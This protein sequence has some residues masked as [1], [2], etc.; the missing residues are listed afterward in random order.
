[1][2]Q[3]KIPRY[4][5]TGGPCAGKT[6]AL[7]MLRQKLT[8]RGI[9]PFV[10]SEVATQIIASGVS[11][12][13]ITDFSEFQRK[14]VQTQLA[15]EDIVESF[16]E[17]QPGTR[18]I[19]ICDRGAMDG[20]AYVSPELFEAILHD[21][22]YRLIELRDKRYAG[23]FHL[24]TAADGAEA[25]YNLDNPARHESPEA[26]RGLD[27]CTREAWTGHEHLRIIGNRSSQ[28][29]PISFEEKMDT[30]LKEFCH[31]LGMPVP[32][33]IERKFLIDLSS[34]APIPCSPVEVMI[35]QTYLLST[36]PHIER[37]VRQRSQKGGSLYTYTEKEEVRPGVRIERERT[38]SAREYLELL[39]QRDP[40]LKEIIKRRFSFE[41]MGQYLQLDNIRSPL[42]LALLEVELTEEN[43]VVTIPHF[44]TAIKEVT[45]DPLYKNAS[46]AAGKCPG[47]K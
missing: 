31:A 13:K 12:A 9:T 41:Y 26:A 25:F 29:K 30:L 5:L 42:K 17:L 33:E 46:I 38:V 43:E 24:V 4:V 40:S 21:M 6:T 45:D 14:I 39:K 28:G 11:F 27:K 37:R 1:V 34:E 16:A 44:L 23:V 3:P 8:D 22:D 7:A 2:K 36:D 20:M 10:V 19:L 15:Q 47:Y 32:L 35:Q 18:K